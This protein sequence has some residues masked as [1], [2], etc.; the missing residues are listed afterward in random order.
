MNLQTTGGKPVT[1]CR[2]GASSAPDLKPL[3][4]MIGSVHVSV[5]RAKGPTLE[6]LGGPHN[7]RQATAQIDS[8]HTNCLPAYD[9][10]SADIDA[11]Q[12]R[13]EGQLAPFADA[14]APLDEIPGT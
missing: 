2:S 12:A 4:V 8:I 6:A 3:S 5:A 7:H 14:V 1:R 9:A 13:T 10:L 11:V